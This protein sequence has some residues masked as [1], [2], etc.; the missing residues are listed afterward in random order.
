MTLC[1]RHTK[2]KTDGQG[3][4]VFFLVNKLS[5]SPTILF[6]LL[7]YI[8][9]LF[10]FTV[11]NAPHLFEGREK[12]RLK[13]SPP[14]YFLLEI[15]IAPRRAREEGN[16]QNLILL[17]TCSRKALD[18]QQNKWG[19]SIYFGCNKAWLVFVFSVSK[20]VHNLPCLHHAGTGYS[21]VVTRG[22]PAL[23][24]GQRSRRQEPGRPGSHGLPPAA[25]APAP[26]RAPSH[27][28][29]ET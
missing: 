26:P 7:T 24:Q 12:S 28:P 21:T 5:I 2:C 15:I 14:P 1:Y 23:A 19:L 20:M 27:L 18:L 9:T 3:S 11:H 8:L 16:S 10:P 6:P 13:F 17:H 4:P 29:P 22:V 25:A